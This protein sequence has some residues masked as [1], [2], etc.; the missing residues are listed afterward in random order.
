MTENI[1]VVG[2]GA[3]GGHVGS[4][5]ARDGHRVTLI[6]AWPAHIDHIREHGL[7]LEGVTGEEQFTVQ[8]AAAL[9]ITELQAQKRKEPFDL[10]LMAVKSYDTAWATVMIADYMAPDGFVVSLQNAINEETIAKVVGW[11][12]TVGAI[13]SKIV[14]ELTEPGKVVRRVQ[15]GGDKH[16]TFRIGECD[17][18]QSARIERLVEMFSPC[19]S[20]MAT[21]NLWGERWSKLAVNCMRNPLSAASGQG[22]NAN[23]R[24]PNIRRLSIRICGEAM[25]VAAAHGITLEKAYGIQA[26]DAIAACDGDADAM[27]RCEEIVIASMSGRSEAARPSMGQDIAKGRRTEIDY[28]NGFIVRKAAEVGMTAPLNAA[29]T[30]I[31][32]EIESGRKMPSPQRLAGLGA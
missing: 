4:Y 6:D 8:P 15:K 21:T 2:A 22:G 12:R 3:L 31:V 17:G 14:V 28:L 26:A 24:D 19:D 10:V 9:H 18:K 20:A 7:T 11:E 25:K 23:D 30:D 5:L 13:A 29:I 32:K 16:T 27:A 1:A